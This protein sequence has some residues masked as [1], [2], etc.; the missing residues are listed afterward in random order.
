MNMA[1]LLKLPAIFD[2][3]YMY[4]YNMY[5]ISKFPHIHT[6]AI[7][8]AYLWKLPAIFVIENNKYGMGTSIAK[9]C[10]SRPHTLVA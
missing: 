7:N 2:I 1:Y 10:V 4:E 8:M 5:I 3:I 9:V 6:Q